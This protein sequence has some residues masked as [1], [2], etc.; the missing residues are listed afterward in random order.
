MKINIEYK[1][2][3]NCAL[4][5]CWISQCKYKLYKKNYFLK[6]DTKTK[7]KVTKPKI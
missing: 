5:K 1:F 3:G 6:K 7:A 4:M 2:Y